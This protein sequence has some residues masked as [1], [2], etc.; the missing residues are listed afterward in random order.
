MATLKELA[1]SLRPK[2]MV[3]QLPDPN[4]V[5]GATQEME[6]RGV[7][8]GEIADICERFPEFG[9]FINQARDSTDG[10]DTDATVSP[11]ALARIGSKLDLGKALRLGR[12]AYPAIIAAACDQPGDKETETIAAGLAF[13]FQQVMVREILQLSF[14]Q[15]RPLADAGEQS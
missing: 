13:E 9:D 6:I 11:E 4:G 14:P 1:A 5:E 3:L 10:E 12:G 15:A 8:S 2:K 7:S